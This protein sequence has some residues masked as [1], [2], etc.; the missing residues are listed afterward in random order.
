MMAAYRTQSTKLQELV[1]RLK[2]GTAM[3]RE[4]TSVTPDT[5]MNELRTLL[6]DRRI[7]GAPVVADGRIVGIVSVEDFIKWLADG[8]C[9]CAVGEKM[10]RHVVVVGQDEPLVKAVGRL[11]KY[12]RLPVVGPDGTTLAGVITKGDVIQQMLHALHADFTEGERQETAEMGEILECLDASESG[13][14]LR[15]EIRGNRIDE[16]GQ[17]ASRLRS[18]LKRLGIHPELVRR[19]AI[20]MYEA[21]MNVI[22]YAEAGEVDVKVDR[23]TIVLNIR[24]KGQGIPDIA[25]AM[26][27]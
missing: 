15:Y 25:R 24:D 7:S 26:Q 10:S 14:W 9:N 6:R 27:P 1:Y 16:G 4:V 5:P 18:S 8:G 22:I 23:D 19:T 3:T 20:A 2:V 21:E 12:G 13:V 11:Q 17:V